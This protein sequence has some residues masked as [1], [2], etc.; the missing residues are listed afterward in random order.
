MSFVPATDERGVTGY[1][2]G[3]QHYELPVGVE[4]V[5]HL[6]TTAGYRTCM[7]QVPAQRI[8]IALVITNPDDPSP[9]LFPA[10]QLM[11]DEAS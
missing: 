1:P 10:F 6:G 11:A 3:L 4:L 5:G 9:V 8:D 7:R 2:L